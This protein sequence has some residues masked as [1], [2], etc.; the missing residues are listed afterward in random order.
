MYRIFRE[1]N[2]KSIALIM[3][4]V[5]RLVEENAM[6]RQELTRYKD[7]EERLREG[8]CSLGR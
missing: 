8:R 3:M 7:G 4:V 6:L 5:N 2:E 1:G